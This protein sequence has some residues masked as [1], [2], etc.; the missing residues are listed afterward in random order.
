MTAEAWSKVT[1][2]V[3]SAHGEFDVQAVNSRDAQLIASIVNEAHPGNGEF[4]LVPKTEHV[5]MK[6][7][8]YRQIFEII[9][10]GKYLEYGQ[11]NYNPEIG[12][13]TT[14]WMQKSMK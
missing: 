9:A 4:I 6:T 5:F 12:R 10:S 11:N 3:L 14:E 1:A 13:I 2:K 8:S 7:D